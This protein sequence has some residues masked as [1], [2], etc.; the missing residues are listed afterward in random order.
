MC[1]II[2]ICKIKGVTVYRVFN[3][4][5][6]NGV[7]CWQEI[8]SSSS[9]CRMVSKLQHY[10]SVASLLQRGAAGLRSETWHKKNY[11]FFVVTEVERERERERERHKTVTV[12]V[13]IYTDILWWRNSLQFKQTEMKWPTN[14]CKEYLLIYLLIYLLTYLF[15]YLFIYLLSYL[16]TSLL[17]YLLIYLLNYLLT[18]LLI[19]SLTYLLTYLLT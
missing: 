10:L 8:L 13:I 17:L 16:L 4:S 3:F 12:L 7:Y 15:T 1:V 19:Y 2:K 18:Y 9:S 14:P 11:S 5:G 6:L